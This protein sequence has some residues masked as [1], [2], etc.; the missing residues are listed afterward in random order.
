[1]RIA[2]LALALVACLGLG[3]DMFMAINDELN[4]GQDQL[5]KYAVTEQGQAERGKRGEETEGAAAEGGDSSARA[6]AAA[7]RAAKGAGEWWDKATTLSSD[8]KDPSIVSCR[9]GG[10][11]QFMREAQ[12][13][14]RGGVPSRS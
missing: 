8:E 10:S 12:C 6:A 13:R 5:D 4:W 9:L 2:T 1:M 3:C 14:A 7:R 11:V